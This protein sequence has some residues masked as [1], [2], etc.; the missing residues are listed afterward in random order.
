MTDPAAPE[1]PPGEPGRPFWPRRSPAFL[2]LRR[3]V[4]PILA[5]GDVV[6]GLSGGPDSLAL[7]A[8]CIAEARR[9][10][11]ARP[12]PEAPG[13]PGAAAAVHAVVVD[14][15][16]QPGSAGIAAAAAATARRLGGTAEIRAVEV[17]DDGAGPE[18][19]A[20]A[21]RYA[22]LGAA[23]ARLGR[24]LL[25]GH[26]L[27]DQAETVL[28]AL[29]RGSGT[30]ALAGMAP[31][32]TGPGGVAL[33]RPLLG[34]R[35]ERTRAACAEL[36][37]APW[38]DPHNDDPRF[39]RVRVRRRLLPALERELGPA[40]AANLARTAELARADADCLDDL[41]AAELARIRAGAGPGADPAG[42]PAAAVAALHP[43]L[44]RRVLA[45]WAR[46]AGAGALTSAHLAALDRLAR[47]A[48]AGAGAG[49]RVR[50][51]GGLVVGHN[52]G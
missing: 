30:R 21:A 10:D 50:L 27:D 32:R 12:A 13:P 20:R 3:A 15:R 43:A 48:A 51:P 37:L 4:R 8:A 44:R 35:R 16:L 46:G 45:A 18:A 47:A 41:A 19:A 5:D 36:G 26:T 14:H 11:R 23:A 33:L 42:L 1:P 38:R 25:L 7:T 34:L 28:L 49:G 52:G 24:P 17:I 2:E 6:V 40:A 22:A 31:R 9:R 39:T 29:A